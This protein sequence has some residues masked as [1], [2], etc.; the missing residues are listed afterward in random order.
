MTPGDL[1]RIHA[2]AF[3]VPRPW[4]ETEFADLLARGDTFVIVE[5]AGFVLGR[6]IA[7]E[8][9]LLTIAVE[10]TARRRGT[11]RNLLA[12][13]L[14]E[15]AR[16]GA[17]VAFLEVSADNEAAIALYRSGGFDVSGRRRG[18]YVRF[19]GSRTDALVMSRQTP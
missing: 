3:T 18:Y 8:A 5:A 19:D 11:G 13:F 14:D 2:A 17:A 9:E 6:V 12:A 16:R 4:S 7:D 10:A 15:V 1:A